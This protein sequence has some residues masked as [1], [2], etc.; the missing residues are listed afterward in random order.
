[1]LHAKGCGGFQI[2]VKECRNL[3]ERSNSMFLVE[4]ANHAQSIIPV[5]NNIKKR[6][7]Y[8]FFKPNCTGFLGPLCHR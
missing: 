3:A 6:K 2:L 7:L 8:S 5:K 1:M 4:Y